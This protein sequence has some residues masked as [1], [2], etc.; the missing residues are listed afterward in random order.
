MGLRE[1]AEARVT[2]TCSELADGRKYEG[3]LGYGSAVGTTGGGGNSTEGEFGGVRPEW[4]SIGMRPEDEDIGER[5]ELCSGV[6]PEG[7]C[8]IRPEGSDDEPSVCMANSPDSIEEAV[9]I[10]DEEVGDGALGRPIV[11]DS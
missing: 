9:D 6:G 10:D 8:G 1:D 4:D 3:A 2:I 5:L 7:E 11:D